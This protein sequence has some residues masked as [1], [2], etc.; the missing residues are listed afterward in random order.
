MNAKL[1]E[2]TVGTESERA[3]LMKVVELLPELESLAN[4]S[5]EF[6]HVEFESDPEEDFNYFNICVKASGEIRDISQ[7]RQQWHRRKDELLGD[8]TDLVCLLIEVV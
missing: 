5:F 1:I 2:E 7:R 8:N 6:D 3:R 4:E